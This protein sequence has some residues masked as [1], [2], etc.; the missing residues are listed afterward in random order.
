[1]SPEQA[2]GK[3][4]DRRT[5]IWAF[6]CVFYEM[7]TGKHA[8]EGETVT[9][10]LAAVIRAEPDWTL[11]PPATPQTIR[12]LLQRCLKKDPKQRLQSIG[13]ARIAIEDVISGSAQDSF[14]LPASSAQPRTPAWRTALPWIVAAVAVLAAVASMFF[15]H[16]APVPGNALDASLNLPAG[17][18]L[19]TEDICM[20]LSPDGK[21]LAL[22]ATGPDGKERLWLRAMDGQTLQPVSGT[23]GATYPFWSPDGRYLAFFADRKLKKLPINGGVMETIADAIDARGGSWGANGEIVYAPTP[24]GALYEVSAGGGIPVEIIPA[25][26]KTDSNRLPYF[27]ADGVHV[28]FSHE[29]SDAVAKAPNG[30]GIFVFDLATKKVEQVL[31][32]ASN[33]IYAPPGYLLFYRGG[34]LM[35]QPFDATNLHVSGD[36]V[37]IAEQVSF[38]ADRWS[39]QFSVSQNGLLVYVKGSSVPAARLTWF[40]LDGKKLGTVG[41]PRGYQD[42]AIS[43][44]GDRALVTALTENGVP[45]LWMA[46]LSRGVFSRFDTTHEGANSGIWS[47]DGREVLFNDDGGQLFE[48]SSVGDSAATQISPGHDMLWAQGWSPD[49][50]SVVWSAQSGVGVWQMGILPMTGDRK[51][52]AY[53]PNPAKEY[54]PTFSADG[55]WISFLSDESGAMELYVSAFPG[56]GG[57]WQVSSGGAL[58]GGW[59]KSVNKIVY[60][61]PEMKL[62][63]VDATAH[64]TDLQIGKARQIFGGQPLPASWNIGYHTFNWIAPDGKRLLLPVP[65]EGSGAANI[66]LVANWPALVKK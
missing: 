7:L 60:V 10:T 61:T 13:D 53:L 3:S 16:Q 41:D 43:A 58:D 46:D 23:E 51:P 44:S 45:G 39:T 30:Y 27:L 2:K 31:Q 32:E 66:S 6:G 15:Q 1:M 5:D 9:D 56:P 48:K 24:Y 4:V 65:V 50:S 12:N 55:H 18:Q 59:L 20:A 8:F 28:L 21:S 29:P 54:E 36:A 26:N 17:F 42:V 38:N 64:G 63:E 34:N 35:A 19:A 37:P 62:M 57:K 40:S 33:A 52:Y 49:G 11:V 25:K 47:P 14:P 22:R